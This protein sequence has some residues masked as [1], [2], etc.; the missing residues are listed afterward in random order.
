MIS[1]T[2]GLVGIIFAFHLKQGKL[3]YN[4]IKL[5][6]TFGDISAKYRYSVPSVLYT[7]IKTALENSTVKTVNEVIDL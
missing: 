6:K 4:I 1:H 2:H 5:F 3:L 7:L